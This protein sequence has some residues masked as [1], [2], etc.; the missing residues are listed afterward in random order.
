MPL[1]FISV[2]L[3][4]PFETTFKRNQHALTVI[5]IVM[6]VP[7]T[8]K[9]ADVIVNAHLRVIYCNMSGCG[10]AI[11]RSVGYIQCCEACS[12]IATSPRF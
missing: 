6:C 5:S 12:H 2:D 3:I 4:G 10:D 7:L 11:P 8:D 9:T 1:D